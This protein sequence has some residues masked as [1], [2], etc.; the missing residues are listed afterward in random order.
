MAMTSK[1][2]E[3]CD[4]LDLA[5]CLY[6]KYGY[7][8]FNDLELKRKGEKV[9]VVLNGNIYD[10]DPFSVIE[11][12]LGDE[13]KDEFRAEHLARHDEGKPIPPDVQE[14]REI[15]GGFVEQA[16][17]MVWSAKEEKTYNADDYGTLDFLLTIVDEWAYMIGEYY[18]QA[19]A[20]AAEQEETTASAT[21]R[22]FEIEILFKNVKSC[23][24][25]FEEPDDHYPAW[26]ARR[27]RVFYENGFVELTKRGAKVQIWEQII[28]EHPGLCDKYPAGLNTFRQWLKDNNLR[29]Q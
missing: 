28:K 4:K 11:E 17:F 25:F 20:E 22:P 16:R 12:Q 15:L 29:S 9:T 6:R 21:G 18:P 2:R 7:D 3:I 19:K 13:A 24:E 1:N 26:W 5:L 8:P 10:S 27:A 23:N 14:L